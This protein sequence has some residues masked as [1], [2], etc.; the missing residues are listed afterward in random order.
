[1][2]GKAEALDPQ[3]TGPVF[4]S[5]GPKLPEHLQ[6]A[7]AQPGTLVGYYDDPDED[8]SVGVHVA[9]DID[10]QDVLLLIPN[11]DRSARM[12]GRAV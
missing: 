2:R 4:L 9:F 11:V 10:G 8:G 6:R 1:M 7:G 12:C 3:H 5:L